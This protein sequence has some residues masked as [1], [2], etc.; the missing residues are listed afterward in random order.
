MSC[1]AASERRARAHPGWAPG[2]S[3]ILRVAVRRL[4]LA[5]AIVLV[6]VI[7]GSCLRGY[8]M[9]LR[10]QL[11]HDE[12]VTYLAATGHL[13]AFDTA[14]NGGRLIGRWE[15]A[16]TWKTLIRPGETGQF[17][18]IGDDLARYDNHPPLY[19]WLLH[20]WIALFG[21]NL[22][23]GVLLNIGIALVTGFV[24][25]GF[26]RHVLRDD[27]Q[28]ALV[29]AVWTLSPPVITTSMQARH[30]DLLA[31]FTVAF[32]WVLTWLTSGRG[33]LR[34][35][36]CALLTLAVAGG[37]LTHY[38]FF[39]VLVGGGV[40]AGLRLW[41][42]DRRRLA[43]LVVSALAG[44]GLFAAGQPLF[45][46]SLRRQTGQASTPTGRGFLERLWNVVQATG[47]FFGS[48]DLPWLLLGFSVLAA[49]AA[50]LWRRRLTGAAS[51]LARGEALPERS[52]D[53]EPEAG[54]EDQSAGDAGVSPAGPRRVVG[55]SA[56]RALLQGKWAPPL[57]F[58][59]WTGGVTVLLYLAFRS[60]VF[61]M[62]DRYLAAVWPF[63][64]FVPVIFAGVFGRYR[65]LAV[66]LFC[67]AVLVPAAVSR[68][69]DYTPKVK[70]PVPSIRRAQH[71][72]VAGVGRG[73]LVRVLWFVPDDKELFVDRQAGICEKREDWLP[74]LAPRDIYIG[75]MRDPGDQPAREAQ[76]LGCLR[77]RFELRRPGSVW[78]L[79]DMWR[80][81][82][83]PQPPSS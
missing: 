72:V 74:K 77:S 26:A 75:R 66:G 73:N 34:W 82:P 44:V 29:P 3:D 2:G 30:Y 12:A 19:F 65:V 17:R 23:S 57:F 51:P 5:L 63:L 31:L 42:V 43:W 55:S 37:L 35:W 46:L 20:V 24:L 11:A 70:S 52:D 32:A 14:V 68:V 45:Y 25:F 60:P 6:A 39:I 71:L 80:L 48:A 58:L 9:L 21:L 64:S 49:A 28:A 50:L 81:Y 79:F 61:A 83:Q 15:S 47:S 1:P 53:I 40:F 54:T 16:A 67:V 22:H 76:I 8:A 59:A 27:L 62:H 41:R 7:A 18:L 38:H 78:G 56:P 69:G 33:R 36:S 4:L 10:E 13:G